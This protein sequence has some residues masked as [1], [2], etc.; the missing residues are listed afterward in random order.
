MVILCIST[1][2]QDERLSSV[3]DVEDCGGSWLM[4]N[5]RGHNIYLYAEEEKERK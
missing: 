5:R 4:A 2:A 3:R 1:T